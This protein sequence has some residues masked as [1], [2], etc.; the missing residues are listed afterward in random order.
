MARQSTEVSGSP[1]SLRTR[2]LNFDSSWVD[3][4]ALEGIFVGSR[5]YKRAKPARRGPV[6]QAFGFLAVQLAA[7]NLRH[8]TERGTTAGAV[9]FLL[10]RQFARAQP[11]DRPSDHERRKFNSAMD[12]RELPRHYDVA[13][14]PRADATGSAAFP[15]S[16]AHSGLCRFSLRQ[17][18]PPRLREHPKAA[19]LRHRQLHRQTFSFAEHRPS[20]CRFDVV[21]LSDKIYELRDGSCI[22]SVHRNSAPAADSSAEF[23][24]FLM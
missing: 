1:V 23:R 17:R 12:E 6:R 13:S 14:R 16:R 15:T 10:L 19:V 4:K 5:Y 11:R 3:A 20:S 24:G 2:G 22:A 7:H 8:G 21:N 9:V 18:P